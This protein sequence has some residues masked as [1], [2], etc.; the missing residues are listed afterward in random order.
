MLDRVREAIFSTLAPWWETPSETGGARVLDLFAGSGSLSLEAL[1]RGA[2]R[3]RLVERDPRVVVVAGENVEALELAA[4]V[5]LLCGDALEPALWASRPPD[6]ARVDLSTDV[7]GAPAPEG[8][9]GWDVVLCDPPYP[10]LKE[11]ETR[12]RVL[13]AVRRLVLEFLAPEGILVLHAPDRALD[14]P[15]LEAPGVTL[16][17]RTYGSNAIWYLQADE[18]EA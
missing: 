14:P 16:A 10:L 4:R 8:G 15:D 1:S 9:S 2:A 6:E 7:A 12:A 13:E 11:P 17:R 5:E 18:V 3:A